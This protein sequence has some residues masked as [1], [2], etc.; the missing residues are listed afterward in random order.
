VGAYRGVCGNQYAGLPV[1]PSGNATQHTQILGGNYGACSAQTARTQIHGG[2]GVFAVLDMTSASYVDVQC[3]D[4][5]DFSNCGRASQTSA[6]Q[7]NG[8]VISDFATNGLVTSNQTSHLLVNNVRFHGLGSFGVYGSTGDGS[9]FTH[10]DILGNAGGGWNAD[11]GDGTTGAGSLLIQNFNISWNGCAEEYPVTH[12]VPY[13]DCTDQSSGGYGDGFGTTTVTTPPPGWQVHFDQGITSYNTQDGLDALHLVGNGSSMTITRTLD[14]GN[15]G[16]QIKVGGESGTAI[17]NV[18]VGNCFALSEAIPGT[19]AGFNSKLTNFCRASDVP[20]NISVSNGNTLTFVDNT[21]YTANTI[22]VEVECDQ[23]AGACNS[24][25]LVDYRNNI[26]VGFTDNAAHGNPYGQGQNP[27]PIY[28]GDSLP[29]G[30]NPFKNPGSHFSNNVTYGQ[31]SNWT[32]PADGETNATCGDPGLVD[33]TWYLYGYGNMTPKSG[34]VVIGSGVSIP[35]VSVDYLGATRNS[36][37]AIG[38]Y[39]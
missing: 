37:P 11:L 18:I 23:Y 34:S 21:L 16:Q 27:T 7:S 1:P 29:S 12:A 6:C 35:G 33:E 14:Y 28:I 20:V 22:G 13:G 3:L 19:P 36:P 26:F 2:W 30:V 32:C 4:V 5:T 39:E 31:R 10:V 38:A 9:V 17:N 25:A 24:T 8:A 15:M